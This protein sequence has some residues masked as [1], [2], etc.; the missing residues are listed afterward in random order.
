VNGR[1]LR[2]IVPAKRVQPLLGFLLELG[3]DLD[4]LRGALL[5]EVLAAGSD[6]ADDSDENAGDGDEHGR[7]SDNDDEAVGRAGWNFGRHISWS[8]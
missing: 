5:L 2:R 4:T 1:L 3:S 7:A 8:V 6:R